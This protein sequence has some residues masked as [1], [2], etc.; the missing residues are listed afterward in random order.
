M[1]GKEGGTEEQLT[2]REDGNSSV[3]DRSEALKGVTRT[4][5]AQAEAE[6]VVEPDCTFP[7]LYLGSRGDALA[8]RTGLPP[9]RCG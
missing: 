8:E 3:G 7:T 6:G 2:T 5:M 1:H 4:S 9:T